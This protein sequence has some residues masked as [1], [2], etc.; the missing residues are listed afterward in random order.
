MNYLRAVRFFSFINVL[1][2][3]ASCSDIK[4]LGNRVDLTLDQPEAHFS[5]LQINDTY[6]IEGLENGSIGGFARLRTLRKQLEDAGNQVLMLHGGDFLFPSVMSKYLKGDGMI[7][8][9]NLMDGQESAFDERMIVVF[10]NHEF[11]DP[12]PGVLLG[13]I[14]QSD[15]AWISSNV[16][17]RS[18]EQSSGAPFSER[19][20]NVHEVLIKDINRLK[21]GLFGI[22]LD[23]QQPPYVSFDYDL[24]VRRKVISKAIADL[25][26]KGAAVIIALTHQT[27]DQ[28][29]WLAHA[30]PEINLI[31]GG[32]EHFYIEQQV[33]KAWITKADADIQSAVL[34][35]VC[36]LPDGSVETRHRK[37]EVSSKLEKDARVDAEVSKQLTRLTEELSN[38]NKVLNQVLGY[39]RYL[40]EGVES[41]VR[42]RETALGNFLTDVIREHMKTDIAFTNGGG[43]RMNDNIPPGPITVYDMEGLFYYDNGLVSFELSGAQLMEVL[44]NSVSKSHLGDGR[45]LQVSGLRFKY[46][47][48]KSNDDYSYSIA[49]AD[50]EVKLRGNSAYQP[51]DINKKYRVATN[52]F[53]WEKGFTDGYNLFAIGAGKS[54]PTRLDN[55]T[56][57]SFRKTVEEAISKLPDKTVSYQIEGRIIREEQ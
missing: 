45:F 9:L 43:I 34:H 53:I 13:R 19:L 37:I 16:R 42:G 33:G 1:L 26:A 24:E 52:D 47:A 57:V 29:Q 36:V 38:K 31:I 6:K 46:L 35:D 25:K 2:W 40:L 30:Y 28:D 7:K 56:A 14:A 10:G 21:V 20:S 55:G 11:D 18:S 5:I 32:H 48:M 8:I 23:S 22:T 12:D 50:V 27:L 3:T 54:S 44:K 17:Y 41:A 15:F 4:V 49:P 39:T 51:L